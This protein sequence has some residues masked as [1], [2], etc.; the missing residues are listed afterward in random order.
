MN[1]RGNPIKEWIIFSALWLLLLIPVIRLTSFSKNAERAD[2]PF[3]AT[4]ATRAAIPAIAILRYTGSPISIRISQNNRLLC[5][6][7]K[8]PPGEAEQDLPVYIEDNTAELQ[9]EAEWPDDRKHVLEIELIAEGKE[10]KK[11][12]CWAEES[13]DE[14]VEFSWN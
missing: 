3:P 11:A 10:E 2:E 1:L 14:I 9:L 5:E 12:H 7:K 6:L 8:P 13:L 4:E